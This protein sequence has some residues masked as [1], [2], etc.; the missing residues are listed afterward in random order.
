MGKT[1][2]NQLAENVTNFVQRY[3]C[4]EVKINKTC[5]SSGEKET[6]LRGHPGR[7][8]TSVRYNMRRKRFFQFERGLFGH[9]L[10]TRLT[11]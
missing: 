5:L 3:Y 7:L 6:Q 11:L 10:L 1:S 8:L 9:M 2:T 4:D